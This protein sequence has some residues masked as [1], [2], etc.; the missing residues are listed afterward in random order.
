[1]KLQQNQVWKKGAEFIRITRL[2]R[3]EVAYKTMADLETKEGEHHVLTKKEFCRLLHG[4]KL[5][6]VEKP[7]PEQDES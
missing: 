7:L 1:M 2:E 5:L 4:A 6:E 3:F